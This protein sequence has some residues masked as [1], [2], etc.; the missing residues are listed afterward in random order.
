M[1]SCTARIY[2]LQRTELALNI[3]RHEAELE[4]AFE[5]NEQ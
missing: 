5:F 2:K 1:R 3:R 4:L